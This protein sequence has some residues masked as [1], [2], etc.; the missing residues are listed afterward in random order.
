MWA[1]S[2]DPVGVPGWPMRMTNLPSRVNLKM[3]PPVS[4]LSP[5][6]TKLL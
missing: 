3:C 4:T 5:T 1:V 6:H 2:F